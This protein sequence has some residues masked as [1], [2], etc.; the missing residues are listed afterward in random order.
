MIEQTD[1]AINAGQRSRLTAKLKR[2][3]LFENSPRVR[4]ALKIWDEAAAE[5]SFI[6]DQCREQLRN[7]IE[8]AASDEKSNQGSTDYAN[9]ESDSADDNTDIRDETSS[10]IGAF[11]NRL[12]AALEILHV[13]V[14]FRANVSD[15][16][17]LSDD[18]INI[19]SPTTLFI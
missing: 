7:E 4:E 11:R 19:T 10:R 13:A 3:Q 16:L 14:F 2:G 1:V 8:S 9:I 15:A 6:V 5:A 18:K 17:L 12:R